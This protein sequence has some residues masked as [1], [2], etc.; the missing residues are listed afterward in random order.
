MSRMTSGILLLLATVLGLCTGASGQFPPI[1]GNSERATIELTW[2]TTPVAGETATLGVLMKVAR[3]WHLQAGKGSPEY[4][5]PYVPTEIDLDLPDGW[6][7]GSVSWPKAHQFTIGEGAYAERLSGYEGNSLAIIEV[8][9]PS[10]A[11]GEH[12]IEA[13]LEYQACDDQQCEMP[14][15]TSATTNVTVVATAAEAVPTAGPLESM[16]ASRLGALAPNVDEAPDVEV[17][18]DDEMAIDGEVRISAALA[19]REGAPAPGIVHLGVLIDIQDAWHIQAGAGSGDTK[20]YYIPTDITLELPS[21]WTAGE[22]IWPKAHDFVIGQGEF[23][24]ELAGY[25]GRML[26]VVPVT[27]NDDAATDGT[28]SASIEYQACDDMLCEE[29]A[30]ITV[31]SAD[32]MQPLDAELSALFDQVIGEGTSG[33][34]GADTGDDPHGGGGLDISRHKWWI[35]F[36]FLAVSMA[37]MVFR[38]FVISKKPFTRIAVTAIGAVFILGGFS[39]T[40]AMTTEEAW[41]DYTPVGLAQAQSEG[42]TVFIDFTADWCA[43]CIVNLRILMADDEFQAELDRGD[44]MAMKVDFTG[45]NPDGTAL[46]KEAGAGGVPLIAIYSPDREQPW[47]YAGPLATASPV[48]AAIRGEDDSSRST[49]TEETSFNILG[50]RFSVSNDATLLI[51]ALAF[52]AGALMNFTPCVLPVV[53]LKILSLQ[54]HAQNPK[55]CFVYGLA[56]GLG[57]I[58]LYAVIGIFMAGLVS[59]IERMNWGDQFQNWWLNALIG[60]VV[61]AMG[62]GMMGLFAIKLPQFLYMFNPQ[63]ETAGGSF[64]MGVFTAI[65]ATPCTG[66]LLAATVVWVA[67]QPQLVA[68]LTLVVMGVG[69]AFPYV[70]LT[71]K[72]G[73]LERLPR[74]GPGSELLKQVMGMLLLSVAAYF[75]GTAIVSFG[76]TPDAARVADVAP[77]VEQG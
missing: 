63:S 26:A 54:A 55:K 67:T 18:D 11:A 41:V 74:T 49:S 9:I 15:A 4:R 19:W 16:F 58:A 23:K 57:I 50:W 53:P 45:P 51:L 46:L 59:G 64:F 75:V 12:E 2:R 33:L 13:T 17:V 31:A 30:S 5:P 73:W 60:V 52:F 65:L 69:M 61:A 37:W 10:D 36:A 44:V 7:A 70:L 35:V 29:P 47:T 72:P 39:F 76:A 1:G 6:T 38:T 32:G 24:E 77:I 28:F 66:P 25:E 8:S 71:A 48:V 3:T 43:I 21:G 62:L 14:T 56:F 20:G 22:T 42:K 27:I 34:A 68:F 40:K